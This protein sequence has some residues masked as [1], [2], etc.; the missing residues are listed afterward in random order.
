MDRKITRMSTLT[1]TS[2]NESKRNIVQ[3]NTLG[4]EPPRKLHSQHELATAKTKTNKPNVKHAS[5]GPAL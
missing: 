1:V 3:E 4:K 5:A 2:P